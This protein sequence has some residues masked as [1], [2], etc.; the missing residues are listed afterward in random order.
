[1]KEI[2]DSQQNHSIKAMFWK[3][4]TEYTPLLDDY[5]EK[6]YD[7]DK[8][9]NMD[10]L[11]QP[12]W[13]RWATAIEDSVPITVCS[14]L[15]TQ[16]KLHRTSRKEKAT[17]KSMKKAD[18]EGVKRLTEKALDLNKKY[19]MLNGSWCTLRDKI[20]LKNDRLAKAADLCRCNPKA[21]LHR[22]WSDKVIDKEKGYEADSERSSDHGKVPG[23]ESALDHCPLSWHRCE[24]V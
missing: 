5:S 16:L 6:Y 15:H 9:D 7:I 24:S 22:N 19:W 14:I 4:K 3:E 10:S 21:L 20:K 8:P 17:W 18:N 13:L 11:Q 12:R 2:R 23:Q 1:M